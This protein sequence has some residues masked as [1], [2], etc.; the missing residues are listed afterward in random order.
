MRIKYLACGL[1]MIGLGL[2]MHH[3]YLV[4]SAFWTDATFP[5]ALLFYVLGGTWFVCGLAPVMSG[6]VIDKKHKPAHDTPV[7]VAS[8]NPDT[9]RV[10]VQQPQRVHDIYRV[11]VKN[12]IGRCDWIPV[13]AT[14]Y[15]KYDISSEYKRN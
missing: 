3:L 13:T 11:K 1:A 14:E 8:I 9:R 5:A 10:T 2:Y 4:G 15:E 12:W 6:K 7:R